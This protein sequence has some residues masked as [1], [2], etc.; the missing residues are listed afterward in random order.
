[1][2]YNYIS[3]P[4]FGWEME[5]IYTYCNLTT[6]A[7]IFVDGSGLTGGMLGSKLILKVYDDS[8]NLISEVEIKTAYSGINKL[9][10]GLKFGGKNDNFA[11]WLLTD[12]GEV[13]GQ[14]YHHYSKIALELEDALDDIYFSINKDPRRGYGWWHSHWVF[15]CG[16]W[17]NR[18][19]W[20]DEAHLDPEY[21]TIVFCEERAAVLHMMTVI[22]NCLK[23]DGVLNITFR[24][25]GKEKVDI[26]VYRY[27]TW[28]VW[29]GHWQYMDSFNGTETGDTFLIDPD[30]PTEFGHL[31][32]RIL[33]KVYKYSTGELLDAV[34]VRTSGYWP[35]EVE[36]GNMYGLLE[37]TESNLRSNNG[38][39]WRAW[40][41]DWSWWDYFD[42]EASRGAVD[43]KDIIA[44]EEARICSN[45]TTIKM[46][47]KMLVKADQLLARVAYMEAEG[48]TV[49][50]A[51]NSDEYAYHMKMAK[52]YLLRGDR[53]AAEGKP[54]RAI[55]DYKSSWKNSMLAVKWA[56]KSIEDSEGTADPGEEQLWPDV[57]ADCPF[58]CDGPGCKKYGWFKGP[59]WLWFYMA[60]GHEDGWKHGQSSGCTFC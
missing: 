31:K 15:Y 24:W 44:E 42:W 50:V 17:V 4:P 18:E 30:G 12:V 21:G 35:L 58:V 1:M 48:F 23:P 43:T 6:G 29:Q 9:T 56:L 40:Y 11:V 5:H 45:L 37:I 54:H 22:N 52:R 33:I 47:I 8:N 34:Y 2:A 46:A 51:N 16:E 10:E 14:S 60:F 49:T 27:N 53:E 38:E 28:W 32:P 36:P 3:M 26:E 41:G 59:W 20:I 19:L 7:K 13:I 57:D 25:T 55:S 39:V